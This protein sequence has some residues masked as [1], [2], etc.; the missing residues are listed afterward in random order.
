MSHKKIFYSKLINDSYKSVRIGKLYYH[1]KSFD[2]NK[3]YKVLHIGIQ[4]DT[5]DIMVIYQEQFDRK[6][7]WIRPLSSW[8]DEVVNKHGNVIKRFTPLK[9]E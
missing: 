3:Y 2:Y 9:K 4:E 6:L 1:Y 5:Q 8:S 7:I